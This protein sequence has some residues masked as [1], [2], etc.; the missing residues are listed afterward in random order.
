MFLQLRIL[1]QIIG[2]GVENISYVARHL[3]QQGRSHATLTGKLIGCCYVGPKFHSITVWVEST[4]LHRRYVPQRCPCDVRN[5][6]L[7]ALA[8]CPH[9]TSKMA[10]YLMVKPTNPV[11]LLFNH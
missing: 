3:L 4:H 7:L 1:L 8:N 10:E 11:G 9:S 5:N 2:Q 6:T